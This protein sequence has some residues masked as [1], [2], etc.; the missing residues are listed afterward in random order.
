LEK[1]KERFINGEVAQVNVN[2]QVARMKKKNV[3]E[4]E[5]FSDG[6]KMFAGIQDRLRNLL[7]RG[8]DG[9]SFAT[10]VVDAF[11]TVLVR[12]MV[13]NNPNR[14]HENEWQ[15]DWNKNEENKYKN[16]GGT[17]CNCDQEN[18]CGRKAVNVK[19]ILNSIL[20]EPPQFK[21]IS[22]R[23]K[24]KRPTVKGSKFD[25]YLEIIE[26]SVVMA[27][28]VFSPK[29]SKCALYRLLV[30]AVCQFHGLDVVYSSAN[31]TQKEKVLTV[32]GI[33]RGSNFHLMN[34]VEARLKQE[35]T[36]KGNNQDCG[37]RYSVP[38]GR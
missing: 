14:F 12:H 1:V 26:H 32:S 24:S 13:L 3:I 8:C 6:N 37:G 30:H 38:K 2:T 23:T 29:S 22:K 35:S 10:E 27:S 16:Q 25:T 5:V 4:E 28:F 33:C 9:F 31:S 34:F 7:L 17:G 15:Y 11:E 21:R 18:S 36:N 19:A 20:L